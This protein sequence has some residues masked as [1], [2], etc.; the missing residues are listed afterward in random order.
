ME[1]SQNKLQMIVTTT[2]DPSYVVMT[3]GIMQE[4]F[5][6]YLMDTHSHPE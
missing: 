1:D 4:A 5:H 6:C 3:M 2:K